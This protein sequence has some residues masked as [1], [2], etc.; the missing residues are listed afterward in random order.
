MRLAL[1][2]E[3]TKIRTVASPRWLLLGT[4]AVTV[5]L[6]VAVT[7][8]AQ[9]EHSSSPSSWPRPAGQWSLRLPML[10][11]PSV[12]PRPPGGSDFCS[13]SRT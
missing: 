4:I 3:W 6:S 8:V 11:D 12:S 1:H 10:S 9:P 5:A 2:A 7:S 13:A